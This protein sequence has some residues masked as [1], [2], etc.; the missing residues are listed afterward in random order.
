MIRV[1][2][3]S[4]CFATFLATFDYNENT[5]ITDKKVSHTQ[6]ELHQ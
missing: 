2:V 3:I 5:A 6:R 1:L 4:V